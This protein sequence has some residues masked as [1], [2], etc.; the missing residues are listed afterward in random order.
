MVYGSGKDKHLVIV[1]F[2]M[3]RNLTRKII[4][5]LIGV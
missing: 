1:T 5:I 2:D 3:T 4:A